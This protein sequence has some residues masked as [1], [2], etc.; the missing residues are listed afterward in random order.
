MLRR[1]LLLISVMLPGCRA[2]SP[3]S[4]LDESGVAVP[5]GWMTRRE[6]A[7]GVDLA[8]VRR[9]GSRPLEELVKEAL[10]N[11]PD[12]KVAAARR[13]Q[14]ASLIR[15]AAAQGLP[16]IEGRLGTDRSQRNFIGFPFGRSGSDGGG[17]GSA[18]GSAGG[19]A[20]AE[21]QVTPFEVTTYTSAVNL[22]WE[23]DVWGRIR[24]GTAAAVAGAE[25]AEADLR[26]A[27]ASLVGQV[28]R[29]WFVVAE[30]GEQEAV[31]GLALQAARDTQEALEERFRTGQAGNE[32]SLGAQLRLA[33]SDVSS[34]QA[35]LAQR[36]EVKV[37]AVRALE[38][39][40]GRYPAGWVG[41]GGKLPGVPAPAPAG[42]PSEL[43]LR[44]PDILAAERRFAAQGMRQKEARRAVFP[45]LALTGSTGTNTDALSNLLVSDYGIWNL[46][47]GLTQTI[48]TGGQVLAEIRRRG[49]E[50]D[51][52]LALLQKTVL[53]AFGEVEEALQL[54]GLLREREAALGE[55]VRLASEADTEAR[56]NYRQGI[57]DILTVLATQNRALQAKSQ[58]TL[59]RR[60]RLDNRV[61]LHLALGGDFTI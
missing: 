29:A 14:A 21:P 31:A 39:L 61:A 24:A 56:A 30:A 46:G 8:W 5:D 3:P 16:Q 27:R 44:R 32:G 15:S 58:L 4:R 34:A 28:V 12:L 10:A 19:G 35:A 60:L 55:A 57:G 48:F 18:P 20:A 41:G 47:A 23:L 52:A 22:Q 38:L 1:R 36:K 54:E 42:L 9:F 45:R 49:A 37:Q 50:Q 25:A 40:L 51:E 26:G 13:D 11:N 7:G 33:R 43:L 59:V 2:V 53:K 17:A 6:A